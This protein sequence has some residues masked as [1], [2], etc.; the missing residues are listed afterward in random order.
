MKQH[1][2]LAFTEKSFLYLWFGEIFSQIAINLLNFFLILI[3]FALTKSNTAVS[4][5]VLSF[6]IPAIIFGALA[7]VFVD[8]WNKK[9]VLITTNIIRAFLLILLAFFSSNLPTIYI[10]SF[11]IALVTQFFI[12]AETPIIPSIVKKEQ[13]LSA[14]A[15][16][17][18]ALYGSILLAYILSGPL[19]LLMGRINTLLV[20]SW[21]FIIGAFFISFVRY[22]KSQVKQIKQE[23]KL[24]EGIIIDLK[25]AL[26]MISKTRE[27]YGSLFF[28]ALSQV[29]ILIIAVV[30]PGYAI[31]V[32]GMRIEEFPLRFIAP[33]ALGVVVGAVLLVNRFHHYRKTK[34][35]SF[36]LFLSAIAMFILPYGSKI[37]SRDIVL[38]INSYIP[39]AL[40]I[41]N[42]H[43]LFVLA[44]L[45][46]FAN[47][48]VF[49]PA[50]TILQERTNEKL[51]GKIYGFLNSFVGLL[52]FLPVIVVGEL[53]DLLG[54]S[55][56]I[57]GIGIF[58][59][60]MGIFKLV[61]DRYA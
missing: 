10:I 19:V 30:T 55:R 1:I 39:R 17:G 37:A 24:H 7:G 3:T 13:L 34:I 51:R 5:I 20:L 31:Q 32:L 8:R 28:L 52:S 40:S 2:F 12:P 42:L 35:I 58:L 45:L 43:I 38:S 61:I 50:N 18:M 16:F 23:E 47:A 56:V 36:G 41:N 33:A 46:G 9:T 15:L 60:I 4:G 53:S 29:L 11:F 21:L 49:V 14:N 44:F 26:S 57:S 54:V 27:I 48:L 6:T 25:N 59:F 22:Q